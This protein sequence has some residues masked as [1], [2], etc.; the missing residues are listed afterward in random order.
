[1]YMHVFLFVFQKESHEIAISLPAERQEC[2]NNH[3]HSLPQKCIFF[4]LEVNAVPI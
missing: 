4:T 1:M 3:P 2:K